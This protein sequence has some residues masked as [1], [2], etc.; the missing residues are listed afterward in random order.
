M[1]GRNPELQIRR[2]LDR[3]AD[4][5]SRPLVCDTLEGVSQIVV[6][7]LLAERENIAATL[8][9]LARNPSE[10]LARTL[11]IAVVNNSPPTPENRSHI[12]NN[13]ETLK[14]LDDALTREAMMAR[15]D[16]A[17]AGMA[18]ALPRTLAALERFLPPKATIR[19]GT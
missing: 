13:L 4:L 3:R 15:A 9:S 11:V 17:V 6:I 12:V 14:L 10:E 16:R 18:G 8:A 2:Y 1:K 7:P 19:H 5:A